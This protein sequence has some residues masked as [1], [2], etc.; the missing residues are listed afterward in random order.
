MNKEIELE[1][2]TQALEAMA[3]L[4]LCKLFDDKALATAREFFRERISEMPLAKSHPQEA[5]SAV[6]SSDE[7]FARAVRYRDDLA[8][9]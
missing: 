7:V 1:I 2:R 8:P 3:S 9:L 5:A 4:L 6:R